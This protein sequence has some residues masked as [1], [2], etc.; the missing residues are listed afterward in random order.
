MCGIA[1]IAGHADE[2]ALRRMTAM[3]RHRGPDDGAVWLSPDG[4]A[5]LGHRRLRVIDLSPEAR[6]PMRTPDG[7]FTL[8]Y[9]GEIFN[10]R[11][12]RAVVEKQGVI[13]RTRSDAEVLLHAFARY[14][15]A[16]LGRLVGQFAFAVWDERERS[17]FAARDHLGV[18][19]LYYALVDGSLF[20]ASEAKALLAVHPTLR[21]PRWDLLP[22]YLAFLWV[23]GEETMFDGIRKLEPGCWM[24]FRDGRLETGCY[25]DVSS[26]D[27]P[28]VPASPAE[29]SEAFR[30][31]FEEAVASQLVSD[32][33]LGLLLS[34]GLDSTAVLAAVQR[35]M[36]NI[37]AFTATYEERNRSEDVFEDDLPFARRAA[38]RFGAR[39]VVR[40][41]ESDVLALLREAVW[42]LDEPL[43]D[44]TVVTNLALTRAAKSDLTV[45][46]SGL[47]A[48]EI[49]AGYPRHLAVYYQHLFRAV[50]R[51]VY[52]S[53]R[54]F[55]RFL[56]TAGLF[57]I[58]RTRRA[59]TL[60]DHAFKPFPESFLGYVTYFDAESRERL[61]ANGPW[62]MGMDVYVHHRRSLESEAGR[63]LLT[64]ML[65]ADLQ[66]FLPCLNLANLDKTSMANA[67]EMRVPF[68]DHRLV[69]F[70]LALPDEDRI[71]GLVRK[72]ILRR[73]Y[74]GTIPDDILARKKTGY[75]PPVRAWVRRVL[76]DEIREILFDR[77][78][79]TRKIWKEGEL[80]RLFD[81]NEKGFAD[82]SMKIW[83]LLTFEI[84]NRIF[85]EE[86]VEPAETEREPLPRV[87]GA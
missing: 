12:L 16:V 27:P 45:L 48:D 44:P 60:L 66:T 55:L 2:A 77:G 49:L 74:R 24:R 79:L 15:E 62:K 1:S 11:E 54:R 58:E 57:P 36:R 43:G 70:A 80:A 3:L 13:F 46:L 56:R 30:A 85:I 42:H 28:S 32:V 71:S 26:I 67:V 50:P 47:G 35:S 82:H 21:R 40:R 34:G 18:K 19:P 37:V 75:S 31:L 39:L 38:E 68:L 51:P 84:W 78:S 64:R 25:W 6:Q 17:L 9:N 14:G 7:R 72:A 63:S 22:Q 59:D 33:P 81:E 86:W 53:A 8:V 61:I 76:K 87:P 65:I 69:E 83:T 5:G 52:T 23:P 10:F 29:R 20:L 41:V 4:S 73:A